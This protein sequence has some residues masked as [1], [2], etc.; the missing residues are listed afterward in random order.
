M[1]GPGRGIRSKQNMAYNILPLAS[2]EKSFAKLP[3]NDQRRIVEKIEHLAA[4][5]QFI[6]SPMANLPPDVRG[7]HKIRVGDWRIFFWVDNRKQEITLYDVG[8][9]DKAY[10]DL[11]RH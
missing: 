3:R 9:R 6:G 10:R 7:L 4:H 5:P 11:F 8:W 1:A 2:F